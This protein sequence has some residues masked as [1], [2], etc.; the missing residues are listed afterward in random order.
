MN[1]VRVTR[2]DTMNKRNPEIILSKLSFNDS[3]SSFEETSSEMINS[4]IISPNPVRKSCAIKNFNCNGTPSNKLPLSP[5]TPFG[6]KAKA[7]IIPFKDLSNNN[8]A[9]EMDQLENY[10]VW[11]D[12]GRGSYAIVKLATHKANMQKCAIKVYSKT[13]LADSALNS[14]VM[15]EIKILKMIDHP[16]IVKFYEQIEGENNLYIVME[17]VRGIGLN[18]HLIAKSLKKLM[19]N[20]ACQ[21]FTQV[22]YA[23]QYCHSKNITHRDIKL[24]NIQL[25]LHFNVKLIDFGF[26]TCY[27]KDKKSL[28]YCGS[29]SYMAPEII[30][31]TEFKGPPVDIWACGIVLYLLVTG[32]F[33]FKSNNEKRVF[34]KIRKGSI[35]I[36]PFISPL[37][38]DLI[39]KIL[40]IDPSIRPSASEILNHPWIK[41][42]GGSSVYATPSFGDNIEVND[43]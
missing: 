24:E 30:N 22:I 9:L 19:E 42:C 14:N 16:N 20:E 41:T 11:S 12:I 4:D 7:C 23:L 1:N 26:A 32:E 15:R 33:P 25:D 39:T 5:S 40:Q 43:E 6:P 13:S 3:Q 38:C 8:N 18:N 21:I 27:S 36:P 37:C 34:E 29:P 17:Y 10:N 31:K 35:S 28:I 2:K